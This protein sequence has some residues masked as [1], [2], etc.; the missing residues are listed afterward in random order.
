MPA[1]QKAC[2]DVG[3]ARSSAVS[4]DWAPVAQRIRA[5]IKEAT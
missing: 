2:C 4:A 1:G 5:G 3:M